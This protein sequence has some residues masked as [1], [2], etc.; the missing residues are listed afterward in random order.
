M[1]KRNPISQLLKSLK[2]PTS[3]IHV[4]EFGAVWEKSGGYLGRDII[5]RVYEAAITAG[6]K[7]QG[8]T[9]L[10]TPDA[11][12]IGHKNVLIDAEGNTLSSSVRWGQT[13]SQN[14][15]HMTLTLAPK[16]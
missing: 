1:A 8:E 5:S 6:W 7:D 3:G 2:F 9:D 13:K 15:F 10:S 14:S 12:T 4:D 11:S 16:A